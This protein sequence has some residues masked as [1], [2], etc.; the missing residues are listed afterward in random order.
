MKTS[1]RRV[2]VSLAVGDGVVHG[3][4]AVHG[5]LSEEHLGGDVRRR[6]RV[7]VTT[8]NKV[9]ASA[10]SQSLV[11]PPLHRA[12]RFDLLP[13]QRFFLRSARDAEAGAT[14]AL[15]TSREMTRRAHR[16]K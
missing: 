9:R 16:G 14:A 7:A 12:I 5:G 4:H 10:Q 8:V 11:S 3:H 15:T 2:A 6:A 1:W 13:E